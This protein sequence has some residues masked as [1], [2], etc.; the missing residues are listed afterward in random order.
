MSGNFDPIRSCVLRLLATRR[1]NQTR[2]SSILN[3][4]EK[5]YRPQAARRLLPNQASVQIPRDPCQATTSPTPDRHALGLLTLKK[6][7]STMTMLSARGVKVE[8]IDELIAKGL[9][10]ASIERMGR[11][12]IEI[13]RVK[14]TQAGERALEVSAG[15]PMAP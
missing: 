1:Q 3:E 4:N 10:S 15:R 2:D 6:H 12:A 8:T 9:A 5:L 7:G 11:G 13:T 14:I